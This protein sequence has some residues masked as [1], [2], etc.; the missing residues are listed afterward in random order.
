MFDVFGP[1]ARAT[2]SVLPLVIA[3]LPL[4][5]AI[6][7]LLDER[8]ARARAIAALAAGA[9]LA[10][11]EL[12]WF[13]RWPVEERMLLSHLGVAARVG[14]L[15]LV[16]AL[17]LDPLGAFA[18]IVAS[19]IAVRLVLA[20]TNRRRIALLGV[21]ASA[22]Q[23]VV[24]ADGAASL[25]LAGALASF[26]GAALGL[27]R[28]A[29]FVAD[30]FADVAFVLAAGLLFW[31]LGGSWIAED[32]V[33]AL[34]AR[35]VVAAS[36]PPPHASAFDEDDEDEAPK[37]APRRGARATLSL[38]TLPG[39]LVLV[40]GAWLRDRRVVRS[41]FADAPIAAGPHTYRLHVGPG[42]DDYVV[43]RANAAEGDHVMLALRGAT[44]TFR[45]IQDDLVARDAAGYAAGKTDLARRRFFGGISAV[46]LVLALVAL[47]LAARARLFPFAPSLD[48]PARALTGFAAVVVAARYALGE[49][50]PSSAPAVSM[51][52]AA[53]SALAAAVALQGRDA[54]ALLAAELGFAGA[55][56]VAGAPAAAIVHAAIAAIAFA[57][58]RGAHPALQL[59][60]LPTRVAIVAA[61]GALRFGGVAAAVAL[62]A[63]WLA[64][65][66]LARLPAARSRRATFAALG[67]IAAAFV[68][69][70]DPRLLG[71]ARGPLAGALF[72]TSFRALTPAVAPPLFLALLT[73]AL[74]A[75]AFVASRSTAL[76][77]LASSAP[78]ATASTI[79]PL[80]TRASAA[81]ALASASALFEL[82]AR[83][84][85]VVAFVD[86]LVRG[87]AALASALDEALFVRLRLPLPLPSD[88][89]T[90]LILVPAALVAAGVFA[91]PWLN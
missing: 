7:A 67:A 89:A 42:S 76:D 4:I 59:A 32:Y 60:F 30:R 55:G 44:T 80:F 10:G 82:E 88:R 33:P 85:A 53:A 86:R 37:N 13:M 71:A 3:L 21:L 39:S 73:C 45:E 90:R 17:A 22:V 27:G 31:A 64:A 24:M 58:P 49:L 50:A 84:C 8:R 12:A 62:L 23:C 68:L 70:G 51:A 47:G 43:P 54:R 2:P 40:D 69:V 15:D 20:Q 35:V 36:A 77:R 56:V 34:D 57:R 41:P 48:E 9:V 38:A 18:S 52:L 29:H 65:C 79:A 87:A 6:A 74:V 75:F 63:T 25:V 5:G 16:L 11:V 28:A 61:F 46:G 26:A 78:I 66:A 81:V 1:L 19:A 83:L 72:E 91:L 14:Q